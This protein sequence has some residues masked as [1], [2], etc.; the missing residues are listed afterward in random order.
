MKRFLLFFIV[1]LVTTATYTQEKEK[2][3]KEDRNFRFA[4]I[5]LIGYNRSIDFSLGVMLNGF[6]SVNQRDT[7]SPKSSTKL[8]GI[9]STNNS[10]FGA[11]VQ[12]LYLKEDKWRIKLIGGM[13]NANLMV[14]TDLGPSSGQYIDYSTQMWQINLDVKRKVYKKLYVGLYGALSKAETTFDVIDPETGENYKDIQTMN[15]VGFNILWDS[16]NDVYYPTKGIQVYLNNRFFAGALGNDSSFTKIEITYNQYF[17][18]KSDRKVMLVRFFSRLSFGEVPFQGQNTIRADD[19]RG[20]SQGKFRDNQTYTLQTEYRHRFK[21]RWG[22][23]A[24]AGIAAAVPDISGLLST[25]YLP[26]V[27][28]GVRFMLIRKMKMNIGIDV[29]VGREDWSLTFRI[30]EAFSR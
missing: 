9:Y 13:G 19:I 27:G 4:G 2:K 10:W 12:Q 21:N 26:G 23:V 20:Y 24:F 5:P 29:G 3:D 18:F 11:F 8:L 15:N 22:F 7:I 28:A 1:F 6:Y 14:W 30:G 16:R 25:Q 17:N